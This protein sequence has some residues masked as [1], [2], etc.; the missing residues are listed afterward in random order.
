MS[1]APIVPVTIP[2]KS[3]IRIGPPAIANNG[4]VV[5]VILA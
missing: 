3:V 2:K 4:S 5:A 1:L